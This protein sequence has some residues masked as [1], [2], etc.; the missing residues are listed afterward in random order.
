MTRL[1]SLHQIRI[2]LVSF[3]FFVCSTAILS[4]MFYIQSFQAAGHRKETL[5]AG[6]TERSIKPA[7]RVSFR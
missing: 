5:N 4:K 1:Y 7:L 2:R 6:L 3:I